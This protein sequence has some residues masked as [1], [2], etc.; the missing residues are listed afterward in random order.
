[1][2]HIRAYNKG[3]YRVESPGNAYCGTETIESFAAAK[4]FWELLAQHTNQLADPPGPLR[5]LAD[6]Q[7]IRVERD[8]NRVARVVFQHATIPD[9]QLFV[10]AKLTL[11][12]SDWGDVIRLS[13]ASYSA[14]PDLKS[15]FG[16]PS[17]PESF[18]EAGRQ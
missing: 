14:G 7:P 5:I 2:N 12:S 9:S 15:R 10:S 6:F 16:E 17:A 4:I 1:M 13:G 11:D 3:N 18:D 8:G